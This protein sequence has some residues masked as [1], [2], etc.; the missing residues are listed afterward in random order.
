MNMEEWLLTSINV[1]S[2]TM[3]G[4]KKI[5]GDVKPLTKEELHFVDSEFFEEGTVPKE[6]MPSIISSTGRG[7]PNATNNF[8]V[9]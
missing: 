6:T 3:G 5:N 2:I 8:K 7:E 1:L 4:M 9:D